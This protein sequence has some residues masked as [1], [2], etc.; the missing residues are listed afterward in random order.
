MDRVDLILIFNGVAALRRVMG[1]FA[2]LEVI[3]GKSRVQG[4]ED[5]RGKA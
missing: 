1:G 2:R 4:V 5:S 3:G